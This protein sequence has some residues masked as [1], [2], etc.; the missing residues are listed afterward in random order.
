MNDRQKEAIESVVKY[1]T[2][3]NE[4][5]NFLEFLSDTEIDDNVLF[6]IEEKIED[7]IT[8][9]DL[10]NIFGEDNLPEHIF[11][12]VLILEDLTNHPF[13]LYS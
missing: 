12:D 1:L 4:E 9:K 2:V 6:E 8:Y 10:V 11:V 5:K 7:G 13:F 3:G